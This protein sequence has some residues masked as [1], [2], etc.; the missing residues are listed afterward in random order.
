MNG[1]E[2]KN[3]GVFELLDADQWFATTG[4]DLASMGLITVLGRNRGWRITPAP[5]PD[6]VTDAGKLESFKP[7]LMDK[8]QMTV[9]E[10]EV[11]LAPRPVQPRA[12][13]T[14][15]MPS[16]KVA[17]D[18]PAL[19]GSSAQT[20]EAEQMLIPQPATRIP[21]LRPPS[22]VKSEVAASAAAVAGSSRDTVYVDDLGTDEEEDEVLRSR[23]RRKRAWRVAE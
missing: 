3:A 9:E 13:R 15:L 18:V 16:T 8:A 20:S 21:A 12:P 22:A 10:Y 2:L 14:L 1:T 23:L 7:L 19:L 6:A 17:A 4:H 5:V 11:T